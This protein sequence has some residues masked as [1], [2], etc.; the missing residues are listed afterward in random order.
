MIDTRIRGYEKLQVSR[1]QG[2]KVS[3]VKNILKNKKSYKKKIELIIL[4][5][6]SFSL[7]PLT[8]RPLGTSTPLFN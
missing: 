1:G 5:S 4:Y 7:D 2:V 3:R 6:C 8:P